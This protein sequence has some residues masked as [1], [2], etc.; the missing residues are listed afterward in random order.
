[1]L[2]P[3]KP[4][5]DVLLRLYDDAPEKVRTCLL[6]SIA[7]GPPDRNVDDLLL[8]ALV[9]EESGIELRK[10]ASNAL[11]VRIFRLPAAEARDLGSRVAAAVRGL[12]PERAA[13]ALQFLG[14]V[15]CRNQ[16]LREAVVDLHRNAPEGG[17][18]Q[19]A[20]AASPALRSVAGM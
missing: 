2:H 20:I 8:D 11:A 10:S 17:V 9:A 18:I 5:P 4:S 12:T 7:G 15:V 13:V 19:L 14:N 1:M 3:Q 6:S 16:P